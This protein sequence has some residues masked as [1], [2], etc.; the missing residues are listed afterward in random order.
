MSLQR[1]LTFL[2]ILS[3]GYYGFIQFRSTL[4]KS[5]FCGIIL[6]Y[7]DLRREEEQLEEDCWTTKGLLGIRRDSRQLFVLRV[8][9]EVRPLVVRS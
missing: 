4:R 9:F 1:D 3:L 6:R 8:Y 5:S 2:A 7:F